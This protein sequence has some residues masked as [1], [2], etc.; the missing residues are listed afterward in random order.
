[1]KTTISIQ[2]V[3]ELEIKPGTELT[4]WRGLVA[5]EIAAHWADRSQWIAVHC[6]GC[7]G[8]GAHPAFERLTID[9]VE[10][11][12]C[13]TLYAPRRPSELALKSWYRDSA[14][15]RYWRERVLPASQDVRREKIVGPRADWI[16]DGIAEYGPQAQRLVDLSPHGSALLDA[17][18]RAAPRLTKIFAAA[19]TAD[20][21]GVA[22]KRVV[23]HPT[24]VAD[25]P[26]LGPA[27]VVVAID[28]FDRAADLRVMVGALEQMVAPG[29][30]VFATFPAASGFEIQALWE[31][32]PT[33]LPPDKLNLPT[34]EG[35][36]R[37]FSSPKWE[38]LELST[39]GMFDVE[40]VRRAIA[41]DPKS[42]WP[43][44]VRALVEQ[45]DVAARAAFV[46]FLQSR[47]FASFARLV[48]RRTP[49]C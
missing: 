34:V 42:P 4:E 47:R 39:P 35:L 48:A 12:S 2:D 32:S 46:E 13:G 23:V 10:C 25:L 6:P 26:A 3:A 1:M 37:L 20:L 18:V 9:Y 14:P 41:A 8:A 49:L 33:V 24:A 31:R 21:D 36:L 11:A 15:A 43:R 45:A 19:V 44:V 27:D 30:L 38:V 40:T 5:A 22:S 7:G 28:V 17:I 29:G 16:L